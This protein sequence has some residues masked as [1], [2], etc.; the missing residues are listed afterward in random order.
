MWSLKSARLWDGSKV[1]GYARFEWIEG[2][3]RNGTGRR[4]EK[5]WNRI[6]NVR[7]LSFSRYG[8]V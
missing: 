1:V 2:G 8:V 7:L 3:R 6:E 4:R 5:K